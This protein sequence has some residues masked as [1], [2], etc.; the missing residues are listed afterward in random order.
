MDSEILKEV[1]RF[2]SKQFKL[3]DVE[4]SRS[5]ITGNQCEADDS[6]GRSKGFEDDFV[7]AKTS[8]SW[9]NVASG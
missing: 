1:D 9:L 7:E 4:A 8:R 5:Y 6:F 3:D 2:F